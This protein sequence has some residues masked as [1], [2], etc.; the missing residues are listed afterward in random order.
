[1]HQIIVVTCKNT[2]FGTVVKEFTTR[3]AAYAYMDICIDNDVSFEV[4]YK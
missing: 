4:T 3:G 1:M 2:V